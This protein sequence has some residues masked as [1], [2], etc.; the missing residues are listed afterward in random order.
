MVTLTQAQAARAAGVSRT[1]IWR[2][3]KDGRISASRADDGSMQVDA[4]ELLRVYPK[5][6]LEHA[7]TRSRTAARN[8]EHRSGDGESSGE[9]SALKSLVDELRADKSRLQTQLDAT[10]TT[11]AEERMKFLEMLATK[12]RLLTDQRPT[13]APTNANGDGDRRRWWHRLVAAKS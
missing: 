11:T 8:S 1:S 6:D 9:I 3:M 2:A 12:D 7:V 5:A 13:A 4:S 10:L